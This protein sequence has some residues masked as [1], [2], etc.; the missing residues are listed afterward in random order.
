MTPFYCL[1][2]QRLLHQA[3]DKY[4]DLE[5]KHKEYRLNQ[6]EVLAKKNDYIDML[7]KE[8]ETSNELFKSVSEDAVQKD[9]EGKL[10]H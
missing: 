7:K 5:T 2:L 8:L 6:E 1:Q 10:F 4:G 3:T 9:L